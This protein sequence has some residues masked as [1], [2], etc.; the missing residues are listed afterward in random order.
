MHITDVLDHKFLTMVHPVLQKKDEDSMMVLEDLKNV[1]V[2]L[3]PLKRAIEEDH[4][5]DTPG[6]RNYKRSSNQDMPC[7]A[8][9]RQNSVKRTLDF[10]QEASKAVRQS[11]S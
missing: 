5:A 10:E 4:S 6:F 2:T 11:T 7:K 9:P 8:A 1:Y 3:D